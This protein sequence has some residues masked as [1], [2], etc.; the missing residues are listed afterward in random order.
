[1]VVVLGCQLNSGN[2]GSEA[3]S[4]ALNIPGFLHLGWLLPSHLDVPEMYFLLTALMMGQPVKLLPPDS[5]LDLDSVWSFLWGTSVNNQPVSSVAPRINFCP[6]AIVILL[7]VARAMV[8][9]D[10]NVLPDWLRNHACSI[11]QVREFF[12]DFLKKDIGSSL[13]VDFIFCRFYFNYTTTCRSSCQR[14][15]PRRSSAEWP[16]S[17]SHSK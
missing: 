15:C 5:K 10:Q 2:H 8:H 9:C 7:S 4:E 6:E 13:Q 12:A 11:I 14:S 16:P 1:M 17:S 3:K